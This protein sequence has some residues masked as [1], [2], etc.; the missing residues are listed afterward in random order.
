M[1]KT[2]E[3]QKERKFGFPLLFVF[4]GLAKGLTGEVPRVARDRDVRLCYARTVKGL[5]LCYAG[6][7]TSRE[8]PASRT[9]LGS[10]REGQGRPMG[11]SDVMGRQLP[12]NWG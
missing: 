6:T 3:K 2:I 11:V 12:R 9:V 1:N 5:R 7:E 4:V 10:R 8:I